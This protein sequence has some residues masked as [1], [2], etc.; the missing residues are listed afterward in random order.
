MNGI[1]AIAKHTFREAARDRV[2]YGMLAFAVLFIF[3]DI[4][5]A[6]LA[7]GD[8]V[9]IKSFGL[10][11][12]YLFG[13]LITV[14]LGSSIIYKEI[15]RRTL[16]FILSKPVSRTQLIFGKFLGLLAAI[17]LT[18][19]L[20]AVVYIAVIAFSGGGFDHIGL[21]AICLQM[22]ELMLLTALL[23]FFSSIVNPLAA[24]ICSVLL[25]FAGHLL[26]VVVRNAEAMGES[27]YRFVLFL[28]Y[29]LPNL[30][31]FDVRTLAAH[32]VELPAQALIF[33]VGYSVAYTA[34][35]LV[36]AI[37]SFKRREL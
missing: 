36:L 32:A 33:A 7:L 35:L 20:M 12:I 29:L 26:P 9:M 23:V 28:Y 31:K 14:F 2:L 17:L 15:E 10:A 6:E 21:L 5:F 1:L 25:L 8:M 22:F 34:A 3:L 18:V 24:T 4:L 19:V 37:G 13:L 11:G 16:Y 27:A 30:E